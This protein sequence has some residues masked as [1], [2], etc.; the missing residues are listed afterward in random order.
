L[1]NHYA[2]LTSIRAQAGEAA[3]PGFVPRQFAGLDTVPKPTV[4]LPE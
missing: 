3:S 1:P 2:L 4:P